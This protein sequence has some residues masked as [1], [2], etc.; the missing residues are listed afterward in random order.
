MYSLLIAA[1]PQGPRLND[2][3]QPLTEA[4]TRMM[5]KNTESA[6]VKSN[7]SVQAQQQ[8]H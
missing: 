4:V 2:A 8:Q 5:D 6:D 3:A 1:P 7:C